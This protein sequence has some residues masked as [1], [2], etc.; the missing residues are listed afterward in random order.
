MP[1]K[2]PDC[3]KTI[4][5]APGLTHHKK[6]CRARKARLQKIFEEFSKGFDHPE[7]PKNPD[8]SRVRAKIHRSDPQNIVDERKWLRQAMESSVSVHMLWHG[9]SM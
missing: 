3:S 7:P 8:N 2:C 9:L 5:S 1:F 6:S 4:K